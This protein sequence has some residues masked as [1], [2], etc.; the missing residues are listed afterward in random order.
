[1]T[2]FE[3]TS[4]RLFAAAAS[5][6]VL[7]SGQVLKWQEPSSAMAEAIHRLLWFCRRPQKVFSSS[8]NTL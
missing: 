5:L 6:L 1:V 2:P 4:G 7:I 8:A 3:W